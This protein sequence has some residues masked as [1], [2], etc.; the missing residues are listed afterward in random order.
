VRWN[1]ARNIVV[2]WIVTMPAAALI[3]ALF[4]AVAPLIG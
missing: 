2:A 3:A 1:V 4:Y